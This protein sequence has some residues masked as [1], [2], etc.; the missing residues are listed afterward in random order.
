MYK[1]FLLFVFHGWMLGFCQEHPAVILTTRPSN[2]SG[3]Y[4]VNPGLWQ[5][6]SGISLAKNWVGPQQ[7]MEE[8]AFNPEV[9]LR[10]G[11]TP[12]A[13]INLS[14]AG[15][16]YRLGEDQLNGLTPLALG[17][18]VDIVRGKG[19]LPTIVLGSRLVLPTGHESLRPRYPGSGLT[20]I[21]A[22]FIGEK[23]AIMYNLGAAW[24]DTG[25][26]GGSYRL[27]FSYNFMP[28][29]AVYA[30][31]YGNF[32]ALDDIESNV[33]A[34]LTFAPQPNWQLDLSG[35]IDIQPGRKH[36]YL[37]IGFSQRWFSKHE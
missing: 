27:F 22:H 25:P 15:R 1:Y 7:K 24:G 30:E 28:K 14:L 32:T 12:W 9:F 31:Y 33:G 23:T 26:P 21:F 10:T 35:G 34:G 11:I 8:R 6:E 19:A 3:P 37:A 18:K 16:F 36:Y 13:E 2:T 4:T 17:L 20:L 5:M 29:L